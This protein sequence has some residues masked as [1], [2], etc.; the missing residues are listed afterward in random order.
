MCLLG[1]T[2]STHAGAGGKPFE[3]FMKYGSEVLC[4]LV[5]YGETWISEAEYFPAF[6]CVPS[7]LGP[8]YLSYTTRKKSDKIFS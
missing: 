3:L 6:F 5:L 7:C 4:R 8:W 2:G 1:F